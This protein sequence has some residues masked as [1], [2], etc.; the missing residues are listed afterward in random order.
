MRYT[1]KRYIPGKLYLCTGEKNGDLLLVIT[2]NQLK[3][4]IYSSPNLKALDIVTGGRTGF[5]EDY[6]IN[7]ED[8]VE[9]GLFYDF[10]EG[11]VKVSDDYK[12]ITITYGEMHEI[13]FSFSRIAN[14]CIHM[15]FLNGVPSEDIT[16]RLVVVKKDGEIVTDLT[17]PNEDLVYTVT[18][19][20]S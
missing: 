18:R 20:A 16:L 14:G 9:K 10:E 12:T 19:A 3:N 4:W 13:L 1:R 17:W 7:M 8:N 2:D 15:Q 6:E 11:T 5:F